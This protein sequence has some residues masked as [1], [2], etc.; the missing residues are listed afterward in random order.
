MTVQIHCKLKKILYKLKQAPICWH[1]KFGSFLMRLEFKVSTAVPCLY[2]RNINGK[3]Y[4]LILYVDDG[5]VRASD[6]RD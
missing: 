6:Q 3:K 5:L 2:I 1:K 4:V